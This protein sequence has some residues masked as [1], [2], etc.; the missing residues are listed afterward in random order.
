MFIVKLFSYTPTIIRLHDID[1]RQT[2]YVVVI[3]YYR[4][5]SKW[6]RWSKSLTE[7]YVVSTGPSLQMKDVGVKRGIPWLVKIMAFVFVFARNV[8]ISKKMNQIVLM[9]EESCII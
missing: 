3:I 1:R 5:Y 8:Y 9:I 7:V 2:H 4:F 6:I